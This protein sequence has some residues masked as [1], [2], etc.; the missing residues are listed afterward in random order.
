MADINDLFKEAQKDPA[1]KDRWF[2][3]VKPKVY[4]GKSDE[5]A[6]MFFDLALFNNEG[7]YERE[8]REL[9]E[10]HIARYHER[11][12]QINGLYT[13]IAG[14]LV[15]FAAAFAPLE[16]PDAVKMASATLGLVSLV[17]SAH[18]GS[19]LRE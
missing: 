15:G 1:M 14:A 6:R 18:Y 11:K 17:V 3:D 4:N 16:Q 10:A 12:R 8:R 9:A 2:K 7:R 19:K 13:G 5:S